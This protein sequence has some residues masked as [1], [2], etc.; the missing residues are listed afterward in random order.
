[1]KY[2]ILIV[3]DNEPIRENTTELLELYNYTVLTANNGEEGLNMAIQQ[4]PDLIL[5]DIQMPVMN[6][7]H[8][9]KH[10][11]QLPYL[12]NS[13]FVF[14]TAFSEKKEIEMGLQVGAND[15]IVKPFSGDELLSKLKKL[16]GKTISPLH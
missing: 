3:E 15:Y 5:C 7:Y 16:L 2:K 4:T 9:L 1:M 8:L 11:R 10:I 12:N 6:G 14:F 13:L